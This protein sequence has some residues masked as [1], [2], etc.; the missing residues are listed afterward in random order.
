MSSILEKFDV[1]VYLINGGKHRLV[2][3]D[4]INVTN[5]LLVISSGS[6]VKVFPLNNIKYYEFNAT[7]GV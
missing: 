4:N 2:F 7:T 6:F 3:V 5:G 1:T